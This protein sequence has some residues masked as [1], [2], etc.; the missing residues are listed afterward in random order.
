LS[1]NGGRLSKRDGSVS[2]IEY[3]EQGF[4]PQALLNYLVRL[5]WSHGDQEIFTKQELMTQFSLEKV[6]K[7]GAVFDLKKLEWMNGMY[8]RTLSAQEILQEL[9][10]LNLT[11]VEK[12][13]NAWEQEQ[14][15]ALIELYKERA[16]RLSSIGID[17]LALKNR[18][19]GLDLSLIQSFLTPTTS[20]LLQN[21]VVGLLNKEKDTSFDLHVFAKELCL[22]HTVKMPLLAQ[23]LRLAITGSLSS[24]GIFELISLVSIQE[25]VKRIENLIRVLQPL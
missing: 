19:E 21:F 18:P 14:L 17:I 22:K 1:P 6:G 23:P 25:S 7:K 9:K 11:L 16:I 8:L 3:R 4:L 13:Q 2:A 10:K 5:G 20:V 15:F 12:L 24:P